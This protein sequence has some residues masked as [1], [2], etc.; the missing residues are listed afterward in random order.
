MI[1]FFKIVL[2]LA[3]LFPLRSQSAEAGQCLADIR[4]V[5]VA[6]GES[7]RLRDFLC[8]S[9][10]GANS[11]RVQFHKLSDIVLNEVLTGPVPPSL[12]PIFAG[13]K[14]VPTATFNEFRTLMSWYAEQ[15]VVDTCQELQIDTPA[16][17]KGLRSDNK[18]EGESGRDPHFGP[19]RPRKTLGGW[20]STT[21]DFPAPDLIP[22][23][24]EQ[25]S[26][27]RFLTSRDIADVADLK[28]Q[29]T[30]RIKKGYEGTEPDAYSRAYME[31]VTSVETKRIDLLSYIGNGNLPSGFELLIGDPE[32][33]GPAHVYFYPRPL[34]AEV[35]V[36]ENTSSKP[37]SIEAL[38]G[39]IYQGRDLRQSVKRASKA[40]GQVP[41]GPIVL[42]PNERALV[43]MKLTFVV[44]PSLKQ[45]MEYSGLKEGP[46]PV[47]PLANFDY[48]PALEL[49]AVRASGE[50][51][52]L[53]ERSSN[54]IAVTLSDESGSCPYL[55]AWHDELGDWVN[56]QKVLHVANSASMEQTDEKNLQGLRTRFRLVETE[57][58]VARIDEA[59]LK[60]ILENGKTLILTPDI[61]TLA[62]R[63]RRYVTLFWGEQIEFSFELPPN[64]R[65]SQVKQSHLLVTGYYERYGD[66]LLASRKAGKSNIRAN[67]SGRRPSY[68]L[69]DAAAG[70]GD[71]IGVTNAA[72]TWGHEDAPGS[73][74]PN[75][76]GRTGPAYSR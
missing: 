56:Y 6:A 75:E 57:A 49:S 23:P 58:E 30:K 37:I 71:G 55:Y 48:G 69:R 2:L 73:R 38:L 5:E 50:T 59:K 8:R 27:W 34:I 72:A 52:S 40:T 1:N 76:R 43:V 42:Q 16:A 9:D 33:C 61:P 35:A 39:S 7:I 65:R 3:A 51:F 32:N 24:G 62:E 20:D 17:G 74:S 13:A 25:R 46:N 26:R 19:T 31:R 4:Q 22:D 53:N 21:I 54:F 18:C 41:V 45:N 68:C 63:D 70:R 36:I 67:F 10:K 15:A 29:I 28:Q 60:L 14:V 64:V 11:L 66:I 12:Q 44:N 47:P